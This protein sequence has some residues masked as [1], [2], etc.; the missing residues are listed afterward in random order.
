MVSIR[1]CL[2]HTSYVVA[3]LALSATLAAS[4]SHGPASVRPNTTRPATVKPLAS[5]LTS[6]NWAGYVNNGSTNEYSSVSAHWTQPTL[7]CT[8]DAEKDSS[9][10]VG[11]DGWQA[12]SNTIEQ[13]GTE[14][15]CINDAPVY[16]GWWELW[17]G[18]SV[19][20]GGTVDAGDAMFAGVVW[21]NGDNY[22][23]TLT[24]H[25]Q[26]WSVSTVQAISGAKRDSAEWITEADGIS[27]NNANLA[28]FGTVPF[29]QAVAN[30][31]A[32]GSL[33]PAKITM[34]SSS[35]VTEVSV[36]SIT[37]NEDFSMTYT[38]G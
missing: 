31:T 20:F 24:D 7:T 35:G 9:F 4:T 11:L 8:S 27:G 12:A 34:V 19:N 10:W 29:T 28:N 2:F 25:T 36:S 18:D 21:E 22:K 30:N 15:D 23:L 3:G 17:P 6:T 32:L 13:V 1:R 37:D 38:A 26:N 33:N 16:Y 5:G 14:A